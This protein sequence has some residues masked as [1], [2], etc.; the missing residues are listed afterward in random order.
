[1][2]SGPDITRL[3]GTPKSDERLDLGDLVLRLLYVSP[4]N[5]FPV[6]EISSANRA[7]V[8]VRLL[9]PKEMPIL[10]HFSVSENG[11]P[12]VVTI[13]Y[14]GRLFAD[15]LLELIFIEEEYGRARV[16]RELSRPPA[17]AKSEP[18]QIGRKK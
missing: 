15:T 12:L 17:W 2:R 16:P 5:E 7:S 9:K 18:P 6:L 3:Y 11:M 1:M 13:I 4:M 10:Q 14:L 8:S